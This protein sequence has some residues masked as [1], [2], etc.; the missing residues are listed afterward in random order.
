MSRTG[1][2][3]LRHVNNNVTDKYWKLSY[4]QIRK[5]YGNC[6]ILIIDDNSDYNYIDKNFENNLINTNII[7]SE[8]K[9]RGELLPYIYYL[10]Y[11]H[12]DIV[13]IIHDSVFINK[14]I[15]FNNIETYKL[16]WSFEHKWDQPNDELNILNKL[17]NN[18]GLIEF[19]NN[20]KLWKGCFGGMSIINY[21]YLK[22]LNEKYNFNNMIENISNKYNRQS[23]E[24]VIACILQYNNNTNTN[25]IS[26]FGDIHKYCN[27]A[28]RY[29]MVIINEE[30][31]NNIK[32]PFIKVWTG[33]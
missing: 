13:C 33:R 10:K 8:Y 28:L 22:S 25:N 23:F 27:W 19:H 24:R 32:L 9:G 17:N 12:C 31:S 14:Y 3:I 26:I 15:D 4:K 21:N 11:K 16:L 30:I 20:K 6:N 18:K 5:Y 29:N 2:I 7:N 1:F